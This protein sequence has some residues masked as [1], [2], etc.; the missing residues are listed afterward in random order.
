MMNYVANWKMCAIM[1]MSKTT[2]NFD[3]K[4]ARFS[5]FAKAKDD[6]LLYA[7]MDEEL[8]VIGKDG[9]HDDQ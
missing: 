7:G 2:E 5:S 3:E 9:A 6:S 8:A 1:K 4:R